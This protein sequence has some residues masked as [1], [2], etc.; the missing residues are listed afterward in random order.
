MINKKNDNLKFVPLMKV[1]ELYN[2]VI[3]NYNKRIVV[4]TKIN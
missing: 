3:L 2:P 1:M 4:Q